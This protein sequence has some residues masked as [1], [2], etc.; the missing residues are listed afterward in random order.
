MRHLADQGLVKAALAIAQTAVVQR[1]ITV[2]QRIGGEPPDRSGGLE[3]G[4]GLAT[5]ERG[6]V[7]IGPALAE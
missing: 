6:T 7:E 3:L 1:G 2:G 4:G 5:V